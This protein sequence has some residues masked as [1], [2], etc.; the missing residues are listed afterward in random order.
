MNGLD[1]PAPLPVRLRPDQYAARNDFSQRRDQPVE[2]LAFAPGDLALAS[3]REPDFPAGRR[4]G[5]A[6]PPQVGTIPSPGRLA[7]GQNV[8]GGPEFLAG[9]A[10]DGIT[11]ALRHAR[12]LNRVTVG[13]HVDNIEAGRLAVA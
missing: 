9:E 12:L 4:V 7:Q 2:I 1:L 5:D 11:P 6:L 8:S 10:G 3:L 13:E